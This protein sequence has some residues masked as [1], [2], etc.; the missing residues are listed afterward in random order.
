MISDNKCVVY[1][2]EN[3][4]ARII[5]KQGT[6]ITM[7]EKKLGIGIDVKSI[8][9][10]QGG[11]RAAQ[12]NA[13]G[14]VKEGKEVQF[15]IGHKKNNLMIELGIGMQNRDVDLYAGDEF[16]L[17]AKAG[18]T[19]TIKIKKN[20]NIGKRLLQAMQNREKIKLMV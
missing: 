20:N 18:K 12:I 4:I 9:E 14:A 1:V 19:G 7:L 13:K 2:P 8:D 15:E 3:D 16:I 5:G 6:N 11:E 10:K 17:S